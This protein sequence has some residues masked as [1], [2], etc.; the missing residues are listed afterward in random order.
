MDI[1]ISHREKTAVSLAVGMK[2]AMAQKRPTVRK[3][4]VTGTPTEQVGPAAILSEGVVKKQAKVS[5]GARIRPHVVTDAPIIP[6]IRPPVVVEAPVGA[7]PVSGVNIAAVERKDSITPLDFLPPPLPPTPS[8]V[9]SHKQPNGT[10]IPRH[11]SMQLSNGPHHQH[12]HPSPTPPPLRFSF[13]VTPP[14]VASDWQPTLSLDLISPG[15]NPST[16]KIREV[17]PQQ[18]LQPIFHLE[19]QYMIRASLP[20]SFYMVMAQHNI[21]HCCVFD[22]PVGDKW[23]GDL[24]G[25]RKSAYIDFTAENSQVQW[26]LHL[27]P[28]RDRTN[29]FGYLCKHDD[30][31]NVIRNQKYNLLKAR[32]LPLVLDLDD[33]LVRLVG[34]ERSRY[35]SEVDAAKVPARIRR[36]KDGRQVVLTEYVEEFLEWAAKFYEISV[37]SLGEQSYVDMVADVL[38]PLRTRIR[39]T[40]YSAPITAAIVS[41]TQQPP[42]PPKDLLSLYAYCVVSKPANDGLP[43]V[44]NGFTLP[45][46]LDDLTQMWPP[47]QHDNV[48][49]VKER[50]NSPVWTVN[51]FP[52]VQHVLGAVHQE[53]FRAYDVW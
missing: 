48:I 6:R 31:V 4:S 37:C 42:A 36:L 28:S 26:E 47:D 16:L 38:D 49:V 27:K 18:D 34:N 51:L 10:S 9:L 1:D 5:A 13:A 30:I 14:S 23:W 46:I 39:G 24:S 53:F 32:R 33:T 45:L 29:I 17:F 8:P 20:R 41:G 12:Q 52:M 21:R 44:G 25:M 40:R 2:M 50:K 35:V 7:F 3:V 15:S 11:G 19:K 43:E 22:F